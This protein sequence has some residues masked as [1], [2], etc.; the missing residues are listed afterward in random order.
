MKHV[1][2]D[3]GRLAAGF[4][5]KAKDCAVRAIAI[6]SEIPY[7]EVF[8]KIKYL[9]DEIHMDGSDVEHG[10]YREV[11]RDF[12]TSLGWVWKATMKIGSGCKVH[13]RDGELPMGRIVCKVSH[14][15][16][17]VIDG[18]IQDT[19]DCSRGGNRCVYGYW[20]KI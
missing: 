4:S 16:V 5:G 9:S 13:L 7:R 10:V 19:H 3:G 11:S 8:D 14:H 20:Q 12:L 18:V 15:L 6:A 17:A 2:N 1:Y